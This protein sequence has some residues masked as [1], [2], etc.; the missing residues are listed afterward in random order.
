MVEWRGG[1]GEVVGRPRGRAATTVLM[2][3]AVELEMG[4][5]CFIEG[6]EIVFGF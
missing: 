6:D 2:E 3:A 1:V 4:F 5:V